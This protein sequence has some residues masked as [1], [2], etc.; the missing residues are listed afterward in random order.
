MLKAYSTD[1]KKL[2]KW[3]IQYRVTSQLIKEKKNIKLEI[4]AKEVKK[5]ATLWKTSKK[6]D[7]NCTKLFLGKNVNCS[8]LICP[9]TLTLT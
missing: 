8:K 1:D 4:W 7:K 9:A 2:F 3:D 6:V 5:V